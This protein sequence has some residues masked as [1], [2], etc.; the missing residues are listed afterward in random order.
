MLVIGS[1]IL[2]NQMTRIP[3]QAE[4]SH[5][6]SLNRRSHIAGWAS[7]LKP[8][9]GLM[10]RTIARVAADNGVRIGLSIVRW[11]FTISRFMGFN[12]LAQPAMWERP[13][14]RDEM[15]KT[16]AWNGMRVI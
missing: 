2:A 9:I 11:D 5:F 4:V 1:I 12:M 16:S 7:M 15:P 14:Q 13:V 8:M 10:V 3:F 6:V